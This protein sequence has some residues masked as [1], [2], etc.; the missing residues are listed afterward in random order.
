M[1]LS[2]APVMKTKGVDVV[3]LVME[4]S[5]QAGLV[6]GTITEESIIP[7][8]AGQDDIRLKEDD[9]SWTEPFAQQE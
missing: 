3:V 9:H 6:R 4:A 1:L 8:W 5:G 7:E 2:L